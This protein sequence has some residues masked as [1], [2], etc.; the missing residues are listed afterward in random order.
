LA[1]QLVSK[2]RESKMINLNPQSEQEVAFYENKPKKNLW[3]WGCGGG[4]ILVCVVLGIVFGFLFFTSTQPDLLDGNY[5]IPPTVKQG[6]KFDFVITMTN[7]T[8]QTVFIKHIVISDSIGD[9]F[10]N[11]ASVVSTEPEMDVDIYDVNA[12]QYSYLRA[13]DPGETQT[14]TYHMRAKNEGVFTADVS[15]Y[16]DNPLESNGFYLYAVKLEI[17]P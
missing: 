8:T 15:A 1:I 14:V 5:S 9:Y 4:I 6:D 7:S 13:I 16:T 17:T 11:G 10:L 3:L 2:G 12:F